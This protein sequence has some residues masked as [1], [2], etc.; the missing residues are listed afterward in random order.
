LEVPLG[1]KQRGNRSEVSLVNNRKDTQS[2]YNYNT[3]AV[4]IKNQNQLYDEEE[5][6]SLHE[7]D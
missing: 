5:I 7:D 4:E 3:V 1:R 2:V 6:E